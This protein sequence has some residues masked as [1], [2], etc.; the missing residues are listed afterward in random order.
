VEIIVAMDPGPTTAPARP[1]PSSQTMNTNIYKSL[2]RWAVVSLGV[3]ACVALAGLAIHS[4]FQK[5]MMIGPANPGAEANFD[6]W[7]VGSGGG[8]QSF[9]A[10]DHTDPASGDSDF[11]LGNTNLDG[12]NFAEWRTFVFPLGPAANGSEPIAFSFAYKLP[13]EVTDGDNV[14]VQ[15]RFYGHATNFLGGKSIWLGSRSGDSAMTRYKT[16]TVAGIHAP[17]R[18]EMADITASINLY[19]DHWSSGTGQFDDFAVLA[20]PHSLL[21]KAGVATTALIGICA[22]IMLLVHFWRRNAPAHQ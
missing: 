10:V 20:A 8:A 5:K 4:L 14:L 16:L 1:Q 13:E 11:T 12:N 9:L 19:G 6:G 15:L 7:W 3:A 18:A 17:P 2:W 21:F 22:L